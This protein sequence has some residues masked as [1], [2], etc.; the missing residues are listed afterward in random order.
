MSIILSENFV[1]TEDDA[2]LTVDH[3]IVGWQSIVTAGNITADTEE[4]LY[5]AS[6]LANPA[7]HL[8]WQ[9]ADTT[10]QYIEIITDSVEGIDFLAIARHNLSSAGIVVSVGY[11]TNDSPD[12]WTELV[13]ESTLSDDGPALFRFTPQVR[14]SIYLK[15]A[16]GA[17]DPAEIAVLYVGKLLVLPRKLYQGLTP[18]P[19]G[20]VSK[21]TNGRSEAGNYLGR[22]ITQ[23]FIQGK[24]PLSLIDPTYYRDHIDDFIAASKDT[25][26]FFGWRPESY[27]QDLG[28]C[29]MTNDPQP[30]NES[31]HGLIAMSLE[32]TGVA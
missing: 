18:T 30:V 28:Y 21:A 12:Q 4:A 5:P 14:A 26:F 17:G 10:E 11:F 19:F 9:A 32:M 1:F 25:P 29:F 16:A 15:L 31:P 13:E 8:K 22:V 3:P 20:R 24:I 6:N 27:P 2:S 7:T 23:E